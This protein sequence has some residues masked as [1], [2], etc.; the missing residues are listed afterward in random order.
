MSYG[1]ESLIYTVPALYDPS[2]VLAWLHAHYPVRVDQKGLVDRS[3]LDTFDWRLLKARWVMESLEERPAVRLVWRAL[4]TGEVFLNQAFSE[5]PG[6]AWDLP[7]GALRDR[8]GPVLDV[9]ALLPAASARAE[10]ICLSVLN[11]D[12]KTVLRLEA[13]RDRP[14]R[15][16]AAEPRDPIT[17]I[18]F[19]PLRGYDKD[20]RRV[21]KLM[22]RELQLMP[23][24]RDPFLDL[25]ETTEREPGRYSSRPE[26]RLQP[27]E[28]TD[29]AAKKVLHE[30]LDIMLVNENGVRRDL[31]SE[32]LHDYRVSI[33]RTRSLLTQVKKIF[34][35]QRLARYRKEFAWLGQVTTPVRDMDV[36]LH[37]FDTLQASLP[38]SHRAGLT[39]L[40]TFLVRRKLESHAAL[41]KA[42]DSVRYR[43]VIE[44]WRIFL[45]SEVPQR[46]TLVSAMRPVGEVA[47]ERIW[48]GYKLVLKEGRAIKK[49]SPPEDLHELRKTC[50]NLRYLMEFFRS[51]YLRGKIDQLIKVLKVFQDNLGE[52]Q[53]L[54]VQQESLTHFREEMEVEG[55]VKPLT[56]EAMER[57]V[58]DLRRRQDKVREEFAERFAVFSTKKN[59]T[60]FK[61]LFSPPTPE[62]GP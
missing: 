38:D 16:P 29:V 49:S 41:V 32:F 13:S 39:D 22:G 10:M 26:V 6:F 58:Q 30:L 46:T 62:V 7:E 27:E 47:S 8:L 45:E 57:L 25:V 9:R 43:R 33:R 20:Y 28:R 11:E 5:R 60:H 15:A 21:L 42:L 19:Q 52:Y 31:D 61:R 59:Q 24:P 37:S 1:M 36:Y 54:C 50:K 2:A 34:P 44:T 53:D 14:A 12:G 51:L 48:K 55:G 56:H 40:K 3:Y 35:Q 18:R 4:E 17:Y 23:A